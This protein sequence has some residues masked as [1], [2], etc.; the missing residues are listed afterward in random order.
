MDQIMVGD[1]A[2][3]GEFEG[4]MFLQCCGLINESILKVDLEEHNVNTLHP[5]ET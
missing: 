4:E 2:Q 5:T 1:N 3:N